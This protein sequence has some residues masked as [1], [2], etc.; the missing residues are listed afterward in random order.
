LAPIFPE[1]RDFL[2]LIKNKIEWWVF[3]REF[4]IYFDR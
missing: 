2:D 3:C 1:D 4:S